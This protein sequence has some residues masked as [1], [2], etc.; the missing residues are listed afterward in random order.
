[1]GSCPLRRRRLD[2]TDAA[3]RDWPSGAPDALGKLLPGATVTSS[4]DLARAV[5]GSLASAASLADELGRWLAI[6]V[7]LAAF[8][9]ASLLTFASI[10][11]RVRE[12]GTLKALGW[13]SRRIV[14]QVL[15][16]SFVTGLVGA[17]GGIAIGLA[18]TRLIDAAAPRLSA[19]VS[20]NPGSAPAS[21]PVELHAPVDPPLVA[22]AVVLV[23]AGALV[24]GGLG[25][26]RACSDATRRGASPAR[27]AVVDD[28]RTNPLVLPAYPANP[29]IR[30]SGWL[31]R[32][33]PVWS[34]FVPPFWGRRPL[35]C[36]RTGVRLMLGRFETSGRTLPHRVVRRPYAQTAS[37]A[38][39]ASRPNDQA[40]DCQIAPVSG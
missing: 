33:N 6:A 18:G 20:A 8:A 22:L 32:R 7:L 34:G 31:K 15:A 36:G 28:N 3:G 30:P 4:A 12:F 39:S 38:K 5:S 10:G 16:E 17:A 9:V 29:R 19:V 14:A 1:M 26:W 24:A 11:R 27:V 35:T 21:V 25:A 40:I 23:L 37:G 13:S 2:R